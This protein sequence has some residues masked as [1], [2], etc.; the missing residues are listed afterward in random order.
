MSAVSTNI[1]IKAQKPVYEIRLQGHL[2]PRWTE[3]F[4]DL[5]ITQDEDG[6]TLLRGPVEDQSAL[7]A[8]LKKIRDLGIQLISVVQIKSN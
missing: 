4:E 5:S 6:T 8:I 3:W 7:H 2:D 1:N